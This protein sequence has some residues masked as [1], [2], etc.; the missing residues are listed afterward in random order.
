MKKRVAVLLLV[1]LLWGCSGDPGPKVEMDERKPAETGISP[2]PSPAYAIESPEIQD[3]PTAESE[4][5]QGDSSDTEENVCQ[6]VINAWSS[7]GYLDDMAPYSP[8]DLLDMYGIDPDQCSYAEGYGDAD[9]YTMEAVIIEAD[10]ETAAMMEE[11][12]LTHLDRVREQFRSY[13][14]VA[15]ALAEKAV[16]LRENGIVLMIVSP[17]AQSML[18][19]YREQAD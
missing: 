13:D 17:D 15:L 10:E 14:P 3:L 18:G 1:L 2:S 11:L 16:M 12:L 19:L 7:A 8:V 6:R 9:G 5:K 4:L